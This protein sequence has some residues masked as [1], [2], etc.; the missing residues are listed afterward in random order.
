MDKKVYEYTFRILISEDGII[1]LQHNCSNV[2]EL[3][4]ILELAKNIALRRID[5]INTIEQQSQQKSVTNVASI[6]PN[7]YLK[8]VM[9]NTVVKSSK[10]VV[11][12]KAL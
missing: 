5:G 9:E 11:S 7:E 1:K 8:Q 3:L 4:G 6:D 10:G 12:L 2:V